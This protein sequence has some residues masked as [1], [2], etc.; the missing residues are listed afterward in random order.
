MPLTR[1]RRDGGTTLIETMIVLALLGT[2]A[3]ALLAAGDTF[4][5]TA[6]HQESLVH[7][8]DNVRTGLARLTRDVR[9]ATRL[10]PPSVGTF[11]DTLEVD[12]PPSG[13][14]VRWTIVGTTLVR[15]VFD[16]AGA[17]LTTEVVLD[18]VVNARDGLA[19]FRY[20]DSEGHE[21]DLTRPPG[22]ISRCTVRV[23]MTVRAA[24]D[25]V[26]FTERD[27]AD[28]RNR[29]AAPAPC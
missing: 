27:G 25:D 28:L 10:P 13:A 5:R 20:Y 14:V 15:D 6:A 23:E 1:V 22:D 2:V 29:S 26:T 8:N 11:A 19:T 17:V 21:L 24:V 16:A 4:T 18:G 7:A 9:A 12:V 3:A